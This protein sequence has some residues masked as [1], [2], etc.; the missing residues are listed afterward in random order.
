MVHNR[1][2]GTGFVNRIDIKARITVIRGFIRG[3]IRVFIFVVIQFSF[4]ISIF[5]FYWGNPL[6]CGLRHN[7]VIYLILH[8]V[9][10]DGV[11]ARPWCLE[12]ST[13]EAYLGTNVVSAVTADSSGVFDVD[14][15]IVG[16]QAIPSLDDIAVIGNSQFLHVEFTTA[17]LA[18][19][20]NLTR[21]S[22]VGCP[23]S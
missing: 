20:S 4:V 13:A 3:T 16:S 12:S 23:C 17:R 19:L 11:S 1:E 10:L 14:L 6:F 7:L 18:L 9:G 5:T 8:Q 15:E 2:F 21:G 22:K